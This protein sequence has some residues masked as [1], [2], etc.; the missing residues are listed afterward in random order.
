MLGSDVATSDAKVHILVVPPP[1]LPLCG[2][3]TLARSGSQGGP[4]K[5]PL[6]EC[7]VDAVSY[8]GLVSILALPAHVTQAD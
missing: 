3:H 4:T 8:W 7:A 6:L 2:A 5:P 1:R